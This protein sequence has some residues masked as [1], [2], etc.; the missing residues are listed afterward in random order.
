MRF[1]AYVKCLIVLHAVHLIAFVLILSNVS[2]T[3][4]PCSGMQS[5]HCLVPLRIRLYYRCIHCLPWKGESTR[6]PSRESFP[7]ANGAGLAC[8][9]RL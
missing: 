3:N 5:G 2:E 8:H 7:P 6:I 4:C 9:H 1:A